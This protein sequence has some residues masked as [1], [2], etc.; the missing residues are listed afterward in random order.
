MD[1]HPQ[2]PFK[3]EQAAV[4]VLLCEHTFF[5]KA[6][7]WSTQA[8][9]TAEQV[10]AVFFYMNDM[11]FLKRSA[12]FD[13]CQYLLNIWLIFI[14]IWSIFPCLYVCMY[15]MYG[16]YSRYGVYNMHSV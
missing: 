1:W 5:E 9:F 11:P 6:S 15:S 13:M 2:R 8:M 3:A 12:L 7:F 10:V 14:N 16:R 4:V